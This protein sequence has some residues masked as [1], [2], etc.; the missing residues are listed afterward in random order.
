MPLSKA[1]EKKN[2]LVTGGAGFIGSHLCERLIHEQA[3]VICVD[4]FMNSS[5]S[6]IEHILTNQDFVF[7]NLDVT[8]PIDLESRTELERFKIPFE[9]IQEIYHLACPT[10]AKHF[11]QTKIQTLRANS[12]GTKNVMDLAVKYESKVV[13]ASS[14]VVY[15]PRTSDRVRFS[16]TDEGRV[17]HLAPRACYD[18]G[19]RFTETIGATYAD[20]Y[21][22]EV[23]FARI[24]RTYGPRL[25][26]DDGH[27]LVDFI[28][29]AL[30]GEDLT[31]YGDE[32]FMT[33]LTFVSD[34]VDGLMK[35]MEAP[36]GTG[37]VNL[38]TDY[39]YNLTDVANKVIEFT[40]STSKLTYVEPMAFTTQLGIPDLTKAKNVLGWFPLVTLDDGL[41]QTIDYTIANQGRLGIA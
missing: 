26:Q 31:I 24:F 40:K 10:S 41:Q 6:N 29:K 32:T 36:I 2:V 18:E 9:G 34:I 3:H 17:E 20:V 16:E 35:L 4:N 23:A 33:S 15:G 13:I 28:V 12:D 38:G 30:A 14:S 7:V 37:P 21:R 22:L 27:M 11:E 19:K 8:D 5:P 25:K 1:F 39:E